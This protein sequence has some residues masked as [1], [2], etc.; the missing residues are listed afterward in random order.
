MII[1]AE[2]IFKTHLTCH[3]EYNGRSIGKFSL[4]L[5]LTPDQRAQLESEGVQVKEYEGQPV[6]KLTSRYEVKMFNKEGEEIKRELP[7]GSK[8]R[9]EYT[10]KSH[11]T[12]GEV[13]FLQRLMVLELGKDRVSESDAEFFAK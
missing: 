2:T 11:P 4:Q 8:V 9:V 7:E 1:E 3:E 10:T 5:A 13:P 12:S 6:R